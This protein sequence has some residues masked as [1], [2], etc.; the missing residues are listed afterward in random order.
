MILTRLVVHRR[1]NSEA[2]W[3][4]P[5]CNSR[6][7]FVNVVVLFGKRT[8]I[9]ITNRDLIV[10]CNRSSHTAAICGALTTAYGSAFDEV[11]PGYRTRV[12]ES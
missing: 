5:N 8:A 7:T 6:I 3:R 12:A 10:C 2:S 4:F 9:R 11:V 1:H